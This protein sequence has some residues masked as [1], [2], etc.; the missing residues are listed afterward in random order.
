MTL[1]SGALPRLDTQL[2]NASLIFMSK[3]IQSLILPPNAFLGRA[4]LLAHLG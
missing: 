2:T 4:L 3:A 1:L